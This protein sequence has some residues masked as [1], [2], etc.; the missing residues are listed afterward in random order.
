MEANGLVVEASVGMTGELSL[1]AATPGGAN[2]GGMQLTAVA[3][4]PAALAAA[5]SHGL[6][7][8]GD[9]HLAAVQPAGAAMPFAVENVAAAQRAAA[10]I[11]S[12]SS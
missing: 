3:D 9:A 1:Q 4:P 7:L 6:E 2:G 10:A 8:G 5:T 12:I 11:S